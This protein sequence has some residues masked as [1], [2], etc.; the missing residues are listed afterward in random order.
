MYPA[1]EAC[2]TLLVM[3]RLFWVFLIPLFAG[4]LLNPAAVQA[5]TTTTLT[6]L[7]SGDLIRG[8]SFS[9]VYYLGKDGFRYVFPNDKTFFTWYSNFDSVKWLTDADLATIQIGGNATY[10][11][12]SRMVK[13]NSDPKVYA[14]D[15]NA[16]L[17]WVT[18]QDIAV[19]L[20]GSAWNTQIDDVP[21]AFFSNYN[22]GGDIETAGDYVLL[23]VT[24]AED[25]INDDK[26]LQAASVIKVGEDGYDKTSITIQAGTA[27]RWYNNGTGKHTATASDLTWGTGTM[28][29]GG[30]FARYFD[31]PG[32]YE[33]FDSYNASKRATIVV[34]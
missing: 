26:N 9:A 1:R 34:E 18:T 31:E 30:N 27:V 25:D 16:T 21:D 12:G 22:M 2:Y 11:P 33:F 14:V 5:S 17:R 8:Q 15:E 3:Q 10:K 28:T 29:S 23:E 20:Y 13:I 4:F 19:S 7:R 24:A 6:Q 32:F